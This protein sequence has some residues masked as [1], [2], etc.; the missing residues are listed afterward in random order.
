MTTPKRIVPVHPVG[1]A[2]ATPSGNLTYHGGSL[3]TNVRVVT[4]FWGAAW[5]TAPQNALIPQINQFFDVVLTS[6]MMDLLR[7]YSVPG[8]T[9]GHGSRIGSATITNSEPGTV[10]SGQRQI[11]D[12]QIQQALQNFIN[13][14]VVPAA[15]SNTLYFVYLPPNVVSILN[16]QSSCANFCGYHGHIGGTTFYA[17]EPFVTCQGCAFDNLLDTLTIVSSHELCEAITDPALNAWFDPT[18][19]NEIGDICNRLFQRIG[20]FAVQLEW[21]NNANACLI[22]ASS[23]RQSSKASPAITAFNNTLQ[24]AFIAN[25]NSNDVLVCSS[26]DGLSWSNNI[27][28]NQSAKNG[29]GPALAVFGGKI[30]VS[31]IANNNSNDVLV[32]SSIDG[33]NWTNNTRVNQA[34]K[35]GA[36]PSLAVFNN[37]LWVSFIANNSSNDVLVCSSTDGVHWSGNTRIN[38]AAKSDSSPSLTVFGGKLWVS[39]VA[40]N[41]SN[42]VLVCSSVDGVHWSGNTR[43]NQA[44]KSGSS[45]SLTVFGGKLWVSFI[46][47]NNSNDV[48]VC[49]STD[50][51]HWSGNTRINQAAHN[52]TSPSL[53]VFANRLW[54]LFIANNGTSEALLCSSGDGLSWTNNIV[55]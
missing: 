12:T 15:T 24:A 38:Q 46:A 11:T 20:N 55:I 36:S 13:T 32:C 3:L 54:E 8:K 2:L 19:G 50:G 26:P 17:V 1:A 22:G 52:N 48:L 42:D 7:Q 14:G 31:F 23:Q 43:I 33:Q 34:G 49:S 4:I 39:F 37:H 29:T 5:Q 47:N 35:D 6:T 51:V 16:G 9:I 10:V 18:T 53:T 45:P 25:N 30:W 44:A 40:N 41:N 27:R 21:S 28:I